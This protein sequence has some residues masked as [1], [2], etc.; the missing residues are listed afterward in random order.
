M[1]VVANRIAVSKGFEKEFED[2]FKNRARLIDRE[3]G[4][5]RNMILRPVQSDYYVVMTF[6]ENREAFQA[7]TQSDSF[8]K[9]HSERPP[10]EMFSGPNVLEIH[11]VF[12]SAENRAAS[13]N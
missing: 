4:F 10:K 3:P 12:E 13:G 11:E 2:R 1:I 7:W 6:W 9:A 5:V 8:R